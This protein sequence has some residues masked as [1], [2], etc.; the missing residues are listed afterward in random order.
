MIS[1]E[2]KFKN[3]HLLSREERIKFTRKL[4]IIRPDFLEKF[5]PRWWWWRR[6]K[7]KVLIV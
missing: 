1:L 3:M 4:E 5:V 7:T 6:C 2:E